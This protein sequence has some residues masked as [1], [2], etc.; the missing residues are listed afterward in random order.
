MENLGAKLYFQSEKSDCRWVR[1]R[2]VQ[3]DLSERESLI[4]QA[5][6]F[7]WIS[8]RVP[9]NHYSWLEI[10]FLC[11]KFSF[12]PLFLFF[13][14]LPLNFWSWAAKRW[15]LLVSRRHG[16][17]SNGFHVFWN[18]L[19]LADLFSRNSWI[20]PL[21]LFAVMKTRFAALGEG[22]GAEESKAGKQKM[23]LFWLYLYFILPS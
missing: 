16:R 3:S 4:S 8:L 2:A 19:H 17:F 1:S 23:N 7:H 14:P 10:L 20:P 5:G 9:E 15:E 6:V 11:F 12:S 22:R 21:F 13:S 18:S